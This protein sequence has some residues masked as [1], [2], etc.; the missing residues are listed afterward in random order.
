MERATHDLRAAIQQE[1]HELIRLKF[2][3][4]KGFLKVRSV[5]LLDLVQK[6]QVNVCFAV[7]NH[8]PKSISWD[9]QPIRYVNFFVVNLQKL[10][11]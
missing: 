1:N 3:Q 9:V 8:L 2:D 11:V 10:T 7:Y 6:G 5:K 4:L